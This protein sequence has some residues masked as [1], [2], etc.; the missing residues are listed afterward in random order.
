MAFITSN[1]VEALRRLKAGGKVEGRA[2]GWLKRLEFAVPMG[3][4]G[5]LQLTQAGE[6]ALEKADR[7]N[8]R[9]VKP[10]P[11]S[12]P[13]SKVNT[14]A[15]LAVRDEELQKKYKHYVVGSV[16][17]VSGQAKLMCEIE[18]QTCSTHREVFTSDVFQIKE[19]LKCRDHTVKT[20]KGPKAKP[21]PT[22]H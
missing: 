18:C 20:G 10:P 15:M 1:T 22:K 7:A 4:N 2:A 6:I 19:C 3:E 21:K 16:H 17:R 11:R 5:G 9:L 14:K 12:K 8:P 13:S